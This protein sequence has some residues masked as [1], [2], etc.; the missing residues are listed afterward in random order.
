MEP[1]NLKIWHIGFDFATAICVLFHVG[2]SSPYML[3]LSIIIADEDN[4]V[5]SIPDT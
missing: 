5:R 3:Q 4:L 1:K 2:F